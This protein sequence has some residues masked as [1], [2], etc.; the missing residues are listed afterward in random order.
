MCFNLDLHAQLVRGITPEK[1][2]SPL[3]L[4]KKYFIGI[5]ID[6]Y[7]NWNI[8]ENAKNDIRGV[9]NLFTNEFG[10]ESIV[11][12]LLDEKASK[13]DILHLIQ[14]TL[15]EKLNTNDQLLIYFAGHGY[16]EEKQIGNVKKLTGY[17]IP[18]DASALQTKAYTSFI[19]IDNFLSQ[20][21]ELPAFHISVI[22]DA[23]HG[24]I[25]LK[26]S[27][28]L[29]KA[30]GNINDYNEMIGKMSRNI[31]VSAGWD[32]L[33]YDSGSEKN[34]SLFTGILMKGL[35]TMEAD[36]NAD[37][38][39]TLSELVMHLQNECRIRG[40]KQF[41][42]NGSWSQFHAGGEMIFVH[43]D[44]S[45][46]K[47]P[48][49]R[50]N[51][52]EASKTFTILPF[53]NILAN[54]D[55]TLGQYISNFAVEIIEN[56]LEHIPDVKVVNPLIFNDILKR[57]ESSDIDLIKLT[58][59][60]IYFTGNYIF[61]GDQIVTNIKLI[62]AKDL[63]TIETL[64]PV[65]SPANDPQAIAKKIASSILI[66]LSEEKE[67]SNLEL[68]PPD[69]EAYKLYKKALQMENPYP[70][71]DPRS[72][73]IKKIKQNLYAQAIE[74][75]SLF[76][77][78]Y[79]Q[80]AYEYYPDLIRSREVANELRSHQENL[81]EYDKFLLAF[82][83]A[84]NT[85]NYNACFDLIK[86]SYL[87]YEDIFSLR[88]LM[89]YG[90]FSKNSTSAQILFDQL[91]HADL[92]SNFPKDW[93]TILKYRI[94]MAFMDLKNSPNLESYVKEY[95]D[96]HFSTIHSIL[97]TNELPSYEALLF[98]LEDSPELFSKR[99]L[100]DFAN[101]FIL[102]DNQ[103]EAQ[104]IYQYLANGYSDDL[105]LEELKH[106]SCGLY[107]TG[108]YD[109]CVNLY[110]KYW[111]SFMEPITWEI[112]HQDFY[113]ITEALRFSNYV[114]LSG[115]KTKN[116]KLQ[117]EILSFISIAQDHNVHLAHYFG[118]I[119]DCY[120]GD[121]KRARS[122]FEQSYSLG[123]S[124]GPFSYGKHELIYPFREEA[125]LKAF[126]SKPKYVKK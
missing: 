55:P 98:K 111:N 52:N 85:P 56:N 5:G 41:P 92:K 117:K 21:S 93:E 71:G 78:A 125:E 13:K 94:G 75:D 123:W 104:K 109:K 9:E 35:N 121:F 74:I 16:V 39:I 57:K 49:L 3:D 110:N 22:L 54:E 107:H 34:N 64:A 116:K 15:P 82:L 100:Q 68:S 122:N 32:E 91:N 28:D 101:S 45:V 47:K 14:Y 53:R 60:Q 87:K 4:G 76:A 31:V 26:N 37:K 27:I 120:K 97:F 81:S 20:I 29:I 95:K 24:G 113:H 103:N 10:Y 58:N 67:F 25:A 115:L 48:K 114:L 105:P 46:T 119:Y 42:R 43:N 36:L 6:Q 80:I 51:V 44:A 8:L 30:R 40:V 69:Y 70:Y 23:C 19:Q 90:R 88:N 102:L 7:Q 66:Y 72:T 2:E 108:E 65:I 17:L 50:A 33:A 73:E 59:A 126:F 77:R 84:E 11:E 79:I 62:S 86:Q 1:K 96:P 18:S 38:F 83:D 124:F 99:H 112:S 89:I 61:E 12:P 63:S 118:G 106:I